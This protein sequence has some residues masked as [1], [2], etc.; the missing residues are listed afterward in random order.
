MGKEI[1]LKPN[2]TSTICIDLPPYVNSKGIWVE[3]DDS[4]WWLKPSLPLLEFQLIVLCFSLAIT[5]FFLKRFG[6]SKIS[7][8][9]LIGLAFGWSWNEWDEAKR[10]HLNVGSQ[11]VLALLAELGYTFYTFLIAAKVDLR[12]TVAT[13][14]SALLIGISALLLPL[15]TETLVVSMVVEDWELTL[16]QRLALPALSSFHAK[17]S[18]PVVASLVKELHIMNSELGRLGLSSALIN[19]IFGTFISTMQVQIRRYYL[20]TSSVSTELGALMMLILVAFFVLRPT[21]FWIIKQTPQGMPV[22]SCYIDGVVSLAFLYIVLGNLTGHASIIGAYVLGLAN[23]DGAPLASTLVSKIESLVENVFMPIFV[24]TCALRADL[25][26]ISTTAFDV[27][28]TK[29]NIILLCVACTVKLV[30]SVSSSKYCKLP[31]KD[32]L[33]LSLIMCS[34]GPVE[35]MAYTVSRDNRFIDNELFGCF[36]V[37][38]LFFATIVPI[39]VIRLYDPSR[40]YAG[41]QNRNIMHLNRFSDK[42]R[43]LACI[44]QHENVN[45]IIHLLNLSCPTIENSIVVHIFHL[46]ELPGQITPIFISHKRQG[47][48]FDK[49]SY[50]QQI[51]R[52][53]DKF[54]RENEGT[55]YVECFTSVSPCT[56]MHND[57]CTLALDKIASFIIL[58]FH[59]TW[60]MDGSIE[61]VDKNVRTLNYSILERAPCSVGIFAHRR[62]LEHFKARKRSSYSVCVIFL[63]GKD[64]REALS[65]A[66]RMVNDLRVELTVLRLQTS[67]DYQN[68]SKSLNSWEHVM[69]E[70]VV[71]DFKEKCLGD[72]RVVYEEEV[73][74]DGQKTAL[75]LRKVVDM[76]DLMIVGRRNG[77]ETPQTDGL[78][79]WNEF[80]ELG[81][82]GDLIASSDINT[83]TSL[84]PSLPL[85][86]FQ[87]I[88]LCFSLAITYFFLKRLGISKISCQILTGLAFG[89]SW[90]EWD[91]AKRK[92]LNIGSQEV[93]ALLAE[94]GYTLY[95]FLIAAKVDLRMTVATGKRALL[96]GI[97]ALLL[98]LITET[99]VVSMVVEDLA[100]TLRQRF[101]LP[102]LSSFHAIISFPVVA[103]LV[104]ELHIMNS[105][106]GRLCLSSA[107]IS[108]FV[109]TFILIMKGHIKRY[110]MNTSRISTEVG[111]L[112]V[113]ILVAFF[114]LRPTMFWI[115]KQT[116]QG[117]PVKSCYIDGVVF[118]ALLYIVLGTFTGHAS[119]IGAYVMGLAIPDGAPLASTLVSKFECLVEDVFM[120]IFVTT[121]A[122]RADLSKISAT[123]FD[124][125]FTKLNIILL[126]VACTVKFVASVSSSRY[127][128]L[129]FKDA[130]ALSL[131]MCS[132]GPVEL[133]FYTIFRDNRFIDNELF[134][135]FVVWILFFATM[136]PIAVKGLYDPSRKYACYQDRNIM[137]LNRF[138]DKLRL[139]ACIHQHEN[140]NAII[141]LL[142][143]SCPTIENSIIV[144]IFHLIELPG[145][146]TPIFISHKRQGNSFDKRSYSQQIVHSFDKFEKENEGTAC[147]ECYTSVSP[148]TV[149]H[150]DVCTLALDK[151][152]SF[153]ILPF[154]ITWTVDG[155]IGRVDKNVRTLNYSILEKAPCSVGIFVHRSKLEHF[156]A[157]KRSSYSVCVIFLG[158]KDDREALSY[159]K[160]MVKDLRV[161]LTVL[162]L[163]APKNYQ[164]RSKLHNSWEYIMDEEVVKDFKGKCLGD[165]RVVYE[166]KICGDGQE[167]AFL[168]R[169][170]VDMFDLMIVG[171]RNGLETP[172]TDGLNE[173]NEFPELGYL[174]DLIA[175]SEIN[176]G[177]SLL[178]IQQQQI[179]HHIS[180]HTL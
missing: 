119:I 2:M 128:K 155:S 133:I 118:L 7:C 89:W 161:E 31:F 10:K 137:H 5:Y 75:I 114:V 24:T 156:R 158:G 56:K 179:S 165:E 21:M 77:L 136:V 38:I 39:A 149:M 82:L 110:H 126:C 127:C 164:N 18:F 33:A 171:R 92:N 8:Q 28:F 86:E 30:A 66:K 105:E 104:K 11:E 88:V 96:I 73:C 53:F 20:N 163:K 49:R 173:W 45:A 59:I 58:P 64:D 176:N 172:Q 80:P 122:L 19:D 102:S 48:P 124:V 99:L 79:E 147:V 145:R 72:E 109:G 142:N 162:R 6:I 70:E 150:N 129:P 138:S 143:L 117:M 108:D 84:L 12:M 153:I 25:S 157:R 103:S 13:G 93:L 57:V 98:P 112:M 51:I 160:R 167:T 177:T 50:S 113:L 159:A 175:S 81:H 83:G 47:N 94:L 78:D 97:S 32:A 148:C 74:T 65:Y 100:L 152:A 44:H 42:L 107:L 140:V 9:I 36:V 61:R 134:G 87:L 3:F 115:I 1:Q 120:P 22:K 67:K 14:K 116:P 139:L 90:N 146:I 131:I 178:V 16:R 26:K 154:H 54:E 95:T 151:I 168:L 132:K 63:G 180:K 23:P 101:A 43:L 91:E 60:T 170:V 27:V 106:L 130:L 169:K 111:A 135:C 141:H 15:I 166:E 125:V 71:K 121:C 46:I 68:R 62:K 123:T 69:D 144:H 76:F 4:E 41:Y 29:L 37:W 40:K 17:S 35:L 34:K 55:A 174:G 85:L 52:S